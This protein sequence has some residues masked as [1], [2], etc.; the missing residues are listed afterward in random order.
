[1]KNKDKMNILLLRIDKIGD[2]VLSIPSILQLKRSHPKGNV[3]IVI[4]KTNYCL[5]KSLGIFRNIFVLDNSASKIKNIS[6]ILRKTKGKKY[7]YAIDLI[8][9]TN[10]FSSILQLIIPAKYKIGVPVG[11]RKYFLT[12]KVKNTGL[13]YEAELVYNILSSLIT[14]KKGNLSLSVKVKLQFDK[15]LKKTCKKIKSL[16]G[17]KPNKYICIYPIIEKLE[18]KRQWSLDDYT[19]L[20]KRILKISPGMKIVLTG[21]VK[22]NKYLKYITDRINNKK[23]VNLAGKINLLQ[24]I[25]LLNECKFSLG[26]L[27]GPSHISAVICGRPTFCIVGGSP[28]KRWVSKDYSYIVIKKSPLCYPCEHL[29]K[30]INSVG[31]RCLKNLSVDE[32]MNSIRR[33]IT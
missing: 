8:Y 7:D 1:M 29:K 31:Y 12:K 28:T 24:F 10:H 22:D 17:L 33:E 27:T 26:G 15:E 23:V 11:I 6:N 18:K 2:F 20:I 16:Y 13:E 9:G 5:A 14:K 32:V 30:C 19:K 3:D 4:D 25:Y 21:S